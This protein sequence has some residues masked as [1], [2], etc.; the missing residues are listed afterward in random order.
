MAPRDATHASHVDHGVPGRCAETGEKHPEFL[1]ECI[2]VAGIL[3]LELNDQACLLSC[4]V[5]GFR[6]SVGLLH[7]VFNKRN[8]KPSVGNIKCLSLV[9]TPGLPFGIT[10]QNM[11]ICEAQSPLI[12]QFG[13]PQPEPYLAPIL[14]LLRLISEG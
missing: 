5:L 10:S 14:T 3:F 7:S 11:R 13:C 8:T 4:L 1:A 2:W 9:I 12:V 6:L